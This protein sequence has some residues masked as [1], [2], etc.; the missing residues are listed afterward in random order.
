MIVFG[1]GLLCLLGGEDRISNSNNSRVCCRRT[2][3]AMSGKTGSY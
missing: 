3:K 2:K 1:R